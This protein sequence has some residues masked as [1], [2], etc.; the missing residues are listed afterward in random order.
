MEAVA[1][2]S[3]KRGDAKEEVDQLRR[4][5]DAEEGLKPTIVF[6]LLN[7]LHLLLSLLLLSLSSQPLMQPLNPLGVGHGV[8]RVGTLDDP[9]LALDL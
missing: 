8:V 4:S 7:V 2:R 3:S 6:T 1:T 9:G 5:H